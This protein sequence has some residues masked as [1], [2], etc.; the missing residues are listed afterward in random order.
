METISGKSLFLFPFEKEIKF[1]T[2]VILGS[3]RNFDGS[4]GKYLYEFKNSLSEILEEFEARR[5]DI[6]NSSF[7]N[8]RDKKIWKKQFDICFWFRKISGAS[9]TILTN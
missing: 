2:D 5:F 9:G 6:E 8:S 7:I 3:D 4:Y 1:K